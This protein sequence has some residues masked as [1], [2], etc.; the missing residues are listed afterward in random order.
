MYIY[1]NWKFWYANMP[2]GNPELPIKSV[3]AF[4]APRRSENPLSNAAQAMAPRR[5]PGRRPRRRPGRRPRRRPR[6]RPQE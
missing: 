1:L 4:L 6:R 5:R 3:K 2:S